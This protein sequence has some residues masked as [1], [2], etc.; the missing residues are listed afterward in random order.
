MKI[1]VLDNYDSFTFNLVQYIQELLG[2]EVEVRRNDV[3]SVEEVE[4]YDAI[5]LS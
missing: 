4:G 2:Q 3:I 1:L 5:V